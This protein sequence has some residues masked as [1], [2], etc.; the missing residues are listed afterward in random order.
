MSQINSIFDTVKRTAAE[1]HLDKAAPNSQLIVDLL[2]LDAAT[3]GELA[4]HVLSQY[5]LVMG[6]YIFM[7][8]FQENEK[9]VNYVLAQ[10]A[11]EVAYSKERFLREDIGHLKTDKATKEFLLNNSEYLSSLDMLVLEAQAEKMLLEN[12]SAACSE[13]LNALKKEKSGRDNDR[14][15]QAY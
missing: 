7:L 14:G 5:I 12:M 10:K 6:Q 1:L 11:F 2:R 3:C 9:N 15:G 8:R 13:L 4:D